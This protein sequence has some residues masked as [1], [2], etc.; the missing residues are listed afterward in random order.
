MNQ[1]P[2]QQHY[3]FVHVYL[4]EKC[5][6]S[7]GG[8]FEDF[9]HEKAAEYQRITWKTVGLTYRH[10]GDEF[11]PADGIDVVPFTIGDEYKGAVLTFP[12]PE[13]VTEAFMSAIVAPVDIQPHES[14]RSQYYTLEYNPDRP[15]KTYIGKWSDNS[16]F[17]LGAGPLPTVENFIQVLT[18]FFT[19]KSDGVNDL[20]FEPLEGSE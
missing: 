18:E 16:H 14:H 9:H 10:P 13:R 6:H 15:N 19:E 11:I 3:Y 1:P 5:L 8:A 2:R 17:N 7:P 4:R 12:T 20:A